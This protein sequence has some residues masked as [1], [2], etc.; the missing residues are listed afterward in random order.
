MSL[1][2]HCAQSSAL[3]PGI[4][5]RARLS[6]PG[7]RPHQNSSSTSPPAPAAN[8]DVLHNTSSFLRTAP[9][10][11]E[12]GFKDTPF[13][14]IW[15]TFLRTKHR[16]GGISNIRESRCNAASCSLHR[17]HGCPSTQPSWCLLGKCCCLEVHRNVVVWMP[18][19]RFQPQEGVTKL[20][21][22]PQPPVLGAYRAQLVPTSEQEPNDL[23]HPR[24]A[25][26]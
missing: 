13:L 18:R 23:G 15:P 2:W 6:L 8:P 20:R 17:L 5:H 16:R 4:N 22:S 21:P 12:T 19:L 1:P 14:V 9:N 7:A 26:H 3:I 24:E 11:L 10:H 25:E